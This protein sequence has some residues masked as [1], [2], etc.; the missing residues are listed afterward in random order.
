MD[1]KGDRGL[2]AH[3]RLSAAQVKSAPPGE[4]C[5]G[6]GLWLRKRTDGGAQWVLR[7]TVHGRRR[8]M[9]LGGLM[10]VS[11]AAAREAA[12]RWRAVAASG[13]DPIKE[14]AREVLEA[15]RA[16]STLRVIALEAF[17]ARKAELKGDGKAGRWFSPLEL[18]VLPKL[19][20]VPV[21]EI[22]QRDIRDVLA[23]IWHTKADTARK[24]INRLNIVLQ[25]AAAL[26]LEVD[27]QATAKA[28]ALLG[29]SR[30]QPKNIPSLP[31]QDVPSFYG[32]ISEP[33]PANL[34]LRLIILT[35]SR[36]APLRHMRLDEIEGDVWTI[37]GDKMKGRLGKTANFRIPLSSEALRV[38]DLAKPFT[39]DGYL[40]AGSRKG[41]LSDMTLSRLMERRGM[42]E[43]PHGF[44]STL[45]TWLAECTEAPHEVAEACIAHITDSAVVRTYRQTDWLEQRRILME[46]WADHVTGGQGRIIQLAKG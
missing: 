43:R 1:K 35:G 34:A 13:R 9:G 46:R 14:R 31:W 11:L 27:M 25:H 5:D 28:K 17:E 32:S 42:V 26:G 36:S 16:D 18:H 7:V 15:S 21:Q 8:E 24:A 38:I 41:V 2:R 30:H 29:K 19:G 23:P 22:D 39:R 20:K 44:R 3:N 10:D 33:T 40:F 12:E 45:R 6:R 4:Y 37:P